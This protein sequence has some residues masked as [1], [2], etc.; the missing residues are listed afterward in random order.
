MGGGRALHQEAGFCTDGAL[1][2]VICLRFGENDPVFHP[3]AEG[4]VLVDMKQVRV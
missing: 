3:K 1:A 4:E 2:Y